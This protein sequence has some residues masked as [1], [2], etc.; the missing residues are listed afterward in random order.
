MAEVYD[1]NELKKRWDATRHLAGRKPQLGD[2]V[3]YDLPGGR[4][5]ICKGDCEDPIKARVYWI[6][7]GERH[8][9]QHPKETNEY[10]TALKVL[11]IAKGED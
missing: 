1:K 5:G 6:S 8:L 4:I 2:L 3:Q 9:H 10:Y 7:Q 11:D